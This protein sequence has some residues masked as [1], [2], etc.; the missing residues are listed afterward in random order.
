MNFAFQNLRGQ[1]ISPL[2]ALLTAVFVASCSGSGSGSGS[3]TGTGSDSDS[4]SVADTSFEI[5]TAMSYKG[6]LPC[7][8]CPGVLWQLDLW[9]TGRFHL[10]QEYLGR[11]T[12]SSRLGH[13][14]L[15]PVDQILTLSASEDDQLFLSIVDADTLRMLDRKGAPIQSSLPYELERQSVFAPSEFFISLRGEFRYFA[16][17]ASFTDCASGYRYAVLMEGEYLSLERGYLAAG[18]KSGA[19]W[20]VQVD[21]QMLNRQAMEGEG[22]SQSLRIERFTEDNTGPCPKDS[23]GS[24]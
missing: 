2:F 9:P 16:D 20:P 19:P 23:G 18:L 7:A 24:P 17:A 21:A 5:D 6:T 12:V 11:D 1:A 22:A 15:A 10:R 14:H 8:D 13:W 3:G 4:D